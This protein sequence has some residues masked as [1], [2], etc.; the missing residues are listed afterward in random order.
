MFYDGSAPFRVHRIVR[1]AAERSVLGGQGQ[2]GDA[3]ILIEVFFNRFRAQVQVCS[4]RHQE[5]DHLTGDLRAERKR[6]GEDP[7]ERIRWYFFGLVE[8]QKAL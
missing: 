5:L 6:K 7:R 2:R 4:L 8:S 3:I 1:E